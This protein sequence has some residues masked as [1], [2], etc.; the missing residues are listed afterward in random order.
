[1]DHDG[2]CFVNAQIDED[3]T[4]QE[5]LAEVLEPDGVDDYGEVRDGQFGSN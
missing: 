3:E 5:F 4:L 2:D 1:M